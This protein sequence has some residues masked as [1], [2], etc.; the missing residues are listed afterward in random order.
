M[1][2]ELPQILA[3]SENE[4]ATVPIVDSSFNEGFNEGFGVMDVRL[5][6]ESGHHSAVF[7]HAG[8]RT[9]LDI[10]VS[11][12]R[13]SRNNAKRD[14]PAGRSLLDRFPH[15]MGRLLIAPN[16]M[17]CRK[18]QQNGIFALVRPSNR[19]K[20]RGGDR[21]SRIPRYGLQQNPPRR[22]ID[23][24]ELLGGHESVFLVTDYDGILKILEGRKPPNRCLQHGV[25][26]HQRDKLLGIE[27]PR[28]WP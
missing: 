15:C 28:K 9:S 17:V 13:P 1:P 20:G 16:D 25:L 22:H 24:P 19:L 27:L 21:R 26:I 12:L 23:G 4:H 6:H 18:N 8:R 7:G 3:G 14:E 11:G 5:L 2:S 10:S